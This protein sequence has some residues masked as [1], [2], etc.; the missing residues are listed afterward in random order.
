MAEKYSGKLTVGKLNV[1]ENMATARKFKVRSI[2][3]MAVFKNGE[4]VNSLL[5]AG[6]E[7]A[8]EEVILS[9]L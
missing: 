3:Y 2:P 7:A 8:L 6:G 4:V 5:G 1:D 9:V